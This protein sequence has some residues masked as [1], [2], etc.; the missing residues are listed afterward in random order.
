VAASARFVLIDESGVQI[1]VD[2]HLLAGHRIQR[3]ACA[4]FRDSAGAFGDDHEIDDRQDREYHDADG[5]VAADHELAE[6]L[7]D[8]SGRTG[9]LVAMKQYHPGRGD[10]ERQAQ[11]GGQQQH[12][13]EDRK[14][15]WPGDIHHRHHD[16]HRQRDVEREQHIERQ[17]GN[18]TTIIASTASSNIGAPAPRC[19]IFSSPGVP[20]R[21][22]EA[23]STS[24]AISLQGAI[25]VPPDG[26]NL[27]A[28]Q[29][30]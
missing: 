2:R 12:R 27:T 9:A 15:E 11:Q 24:S 7:D 23:L 14:V 17:G 19:N 13:R 20:R 10:V 18:G 16:Q 3:E 6:G 26:D 4:D 25:L 21:A 1:R 29:G 5:V 30:L 8:V 28:H 22:A